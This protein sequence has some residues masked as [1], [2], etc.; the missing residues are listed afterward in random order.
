MGHSLPTTIEILEYTRE[1]SDAHAPPEKKYTIEFSRS[2]IWPG[3][4]SR[5]EQ[6][7]TREEK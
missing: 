3:I 6:H 4:P 2:F 5:A 7:R 1:E